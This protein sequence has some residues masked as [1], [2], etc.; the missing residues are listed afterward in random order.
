MMDVQARAWR[1]VQAIVAPL[2]EPATVAI[3]THGDVIR[4]ILLLLLGIPMDHIH[5]IE[6]APGSLSEFTTENGHVVVRS[7]NQIFY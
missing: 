6:V 7:M 3:V 4:C 2:N 5:R 1:A